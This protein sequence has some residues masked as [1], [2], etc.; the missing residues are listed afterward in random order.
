MP[1]WVHYI[2]AVYEFTLNFRKTY[3][4]KVLQYWYYFYILLAVTIIQLSVAVVCCDN[5]PVNTYNPTNTSQ[6]PNHASGSLVL[7]VQ[8]ISLP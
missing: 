4:E 5:L 1:S 3:F 7:I 6:P 8:A 2:T